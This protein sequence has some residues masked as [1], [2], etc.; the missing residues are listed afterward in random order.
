MTNDELQAIVESNAR[1]I[2]ATNEGIAGLRSQQE[3]N[4]A[5]ITD[6]ITL[7]GNVLMAV[8]GLVAK[9][10]GFVTKIDESNERFDTLRREAIADRQ[11]SDERFDRMLLE[12]RGVAGR[13]ETLEQAS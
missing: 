4:T 3:I 12:V 9:V 1:A 11:R 13:V 10:D 7:S 2:A 8:D 5:N 6:L